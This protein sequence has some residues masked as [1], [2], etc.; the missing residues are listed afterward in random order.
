MYFAFTS[1]V[2]Y[3][4]ISPRR[5]NFLKFLGAETRLLKYSM[6][7]KTEYIVLTHILSLCSAY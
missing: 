5:S 2:L 7:S 4:V 1:F 3:V 6:R